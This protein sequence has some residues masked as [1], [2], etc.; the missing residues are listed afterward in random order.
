MKSIQC[1]QISSTD[2][3]FV[4]TGG[5]VEKVKVVMLD[6]IKE[7]HLKDL[8]MT[9]QDLYDSQHVIQLKMDSILMTHP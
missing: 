2:C 5:H 1:K 6:H 7:N 4:A 9:K 3:N 8:K